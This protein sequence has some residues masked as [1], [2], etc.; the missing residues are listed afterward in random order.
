VSKR[1]LKAG[2]KYLV[3]LF[4]LYPQFCFSQLN[5]KYFGDLLNENGA[6]IELLLVKPR[7]N[8]GVGSRDWTYKIRAFNLGNIPIR[9]KYLNWKLKTLNC[10]NYVIERIF[11]IDLSTLIKNTSANQGMSDWTFE[12]QEII[13]GIKDVKLSSVDLSEKDKN[14]G[15]LNNLPVPD[16]ILGITNVEKDQF[17]TLKAIGNLSDETRWVWYEN[18]CG[19][20]KP[21]FKGFIFRTK[22]IKNTTYYVRSENQNGF[23]KCVPVVLKVYDKAI[24][25]E[26]ITSNDGNDW[27][28]PD[29][30]NNQFKTL[31]VSGK[32]ASEDFKW[33]WYENN[34][35]DTSKIIEGSN[36]IVVN[37]KVTTTFIVRAESQFMIS[38]IVSF[39]V[40]V[41]KVSV[42][43]DAIIPSI[44]D[45]ICAGQK[46][47]LIRKGGSLSEGSEWVW[48]KNAGIKGFEEIGK[49]D[50]ITLY[51][52]STSY[53]FVYAKGYCSFSE[54]AVI[55][56]P[57]LKTSRLPE[58]SEIL[59]EVNKK[60]QRATLT[61]KGGS[62]LEGYYWEWFTLEPEEK[63]L[64]K[65]SKITF[66]YE[67]YKKVHLRFQG[68]C[69]YSN[70]YLTFENLSN[71]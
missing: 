36:A 46:I 27:I 44:S 14:L 37:P 6:K 25:P 61:I 8:C 54:A 23:S 68:G 71:E 19:E 26:K 33:V 50:K 64:F 11:T 34:V 67:L 38:D 24:N 62:L 51:P 1:I 65:G 4:F 12:A 47:E 22:V 2:Y 29:S 9:T 39:T 31:A 45:D 15:K 60:L 48:L 21:V 70:K 3:I 30:K 69:D 7:I 42:K 66:D 59:V 5:A 43:P 35:N 56:I 17:T 63:I 40:K 28:C 10:E 41:N 57:V 55:R 16:S 52:D 13:D 18:A 32:L 53:V 20:G 49:G 58:K